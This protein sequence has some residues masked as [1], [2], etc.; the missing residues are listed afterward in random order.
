MD[1]LTLPLTLSVEIRVH[2]A[3]REE[4]LRALRQLFDAFARIATFLDATVHTSEDEPNLIVVMERWAETKESFARDRL[5]DPAFAPFLAVFDRV[6]GISRT[7][8]WLQERHR[9]Q[10]GAQR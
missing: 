2:P 4:L 10:S 5:S 9:W 1:P 6:G 8:H 3:G 7:P